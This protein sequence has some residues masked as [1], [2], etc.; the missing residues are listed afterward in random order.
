MEKLRNT[1]WQWSAQFVVAA[2]A[3]LIPVAGVPAKAAP[4]DYWK[5]LQAIARDIAKLATDFPQLKDFSPTENADIQRLALD[6]G[7]RTHQAQHRGG[8]TSEVPNP[9]DDG[10]WFY[11][12]FHEPDSQA[13]IHTQPVVAKLCLADKR[14]S[15]LILEGKSTKSVAGRIGNILRSHGVKECD[16]AR[17][18]QVDK[19]APRRIN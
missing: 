10:I 2:C 1:L 6:Y 4:K 5:A 9:D 19:N 12:D 13:Q 11:I 3:L 17:S 18:K 8:W 16:K 7:Y 15:L 14:V